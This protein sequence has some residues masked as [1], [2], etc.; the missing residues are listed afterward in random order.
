MI[1]TPI[2]PIIKICLALMRPT[3]I[4]SIEDANNIAAV[5]KFA[6]RIRRQTT[7]TQPMI[8]INVLLKSL[9][10]SC[11]KDNCLATNIIIASLAKS[12]VWNEKPSLAE[13]ASG[14]LR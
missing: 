4:N 11:F 6:G 3:N 10:V 13:L 8:G 12:D 5:L 9:I 7:D 2:P 14:K 1:T